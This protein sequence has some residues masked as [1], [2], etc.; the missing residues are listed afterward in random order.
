MN[1]TA[2][3]YSGPRK[4]LISHTALWW[5]RFQIRLWHWEYWPMYVFNIPVL[6]IWVW[7]AIRCRD[8]FFFT[9]TNPGIPTGGFFGES[10]S[11]I[12]QTIPDAYKAKTILWKGPVSE[13]DVEKLFEQSGLTFPIIAKPEVGER[14]W[15]IAKISSLEELKQHIRRHQIDLILQPFIT[16]STEVSIMVYRYPDGTRADV[17][18]ICQKEF[19]HIVGDGTSTMEALILAQDRAVLQHEKLTRTYGHRFDEILDAGEYLLLEPIGNHC[20]GTKFINANAQIDD[21]IR[22]VMT[23]ILQSMPGLYY[24]RFDMKIDSWASLRAGKGIYILEFNGTS[25]DPAHIYDPSYSLVRAY[26]DIAFHWG[27]M[28]RIAR[29]NRRAGIKSVGIKQII[30]ALFLYFRYKSTNEI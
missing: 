9:L 20:R 15:L 18:S 11:D 27:I 19:L 7:N 12:L 6:F 8:L 25:S 22:A 1:N 29:Q 14:G 28:G 26:R 3:T 17:S 21:A 23:G 5:R 4:S 2:T 24:G 16:A 30:P 13:H 10:K